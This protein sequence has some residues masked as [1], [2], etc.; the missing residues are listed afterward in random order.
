MAMDTL[1]L[2]LSG[3]VLLDELTQGLTTLQGL[4]DALGREV[5]SRAA[6]D[7]RVEDLAPG[8]ARVCVRG[9]ARRE[10]D[11]PM[12]QRVVEAYAKV[13][14]ALES[15]RQVPYSSSVAIAAAGLVALIGDHI[16]SITL[17]TE[18]QGLDG[19]P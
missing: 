11:Q 18:D 8:S 5:A 19:D 10:H 12:V 3:E 1:T 15:G 4:I 14:A 17:E 6:I 16:D 9:I 7:W 2:V 13:G